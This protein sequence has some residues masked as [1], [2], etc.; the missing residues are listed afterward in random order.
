MYEFRDPTGQ[1]KMSSPFTSKV[2]KP[3]KN[4][5][6]ARQGDRF[7][8]SCASLNRRV[9]GLLFNRITQLFLDS[10]CAG[11]AFFL[12]FQLRFDGS[13]SPK[14]R[15]IMLVWLAAVIVLR[16]F[17]IWVLGAY[18]S[19]WRYFNL[20]DMFS[21]SLAAALPST[22]L[23]FARIVLA[24]TFWFMAI[25]ISIVLIDLGLFLILVG[26]LRALRRAGFESWRVS[27]SHRHRAVLLGTGDTLASGVRQ[28]SL[29]NDI[30][31]V[32]LLSPDPH[33]HGRRIAGFPVVEL[34]DDA[35]P[36]VL[37]NYCV[38][39]VFIAEA[40]LDC[41]DEIVQDTTQ[42]G[43]EVR[44]LPS[45]ANIMR[46][47]VRIS[48]KLNPEHVLD[49]RGASLETPHPDVIRGFEGKNVLITGAG[50]SIGSE[51]S[52]QVSR[53]GVNKA[54]LLDRDENSIFELQ[55]QLTELG[56]ASQIL[57]LVGD[58]RD[59]HQL[60]QIFERH[61][62]EVVLHAAAFKHVGI[63]EQNPCEAVLNNV[64]GTR[65]LA[66]L[67]IEFEAKRFL[68]ISTDK[69]VRPT[70]V[71]GATK[72]VAELLVRGLAGSSGHN[73][74]I[75][76]VRFGNVVGSR[77]S[78]VPIFLRQIAAGGP[79]T[80]THEEMTRYFMTI[81]EAVQ[82]VM[83]ASTLAS[84][85]TIYTLDLGDPLRI[86]HLAHKLIEMS[87]LRPEKDIKI[88][89]VGVRPGEKLHE[90]LWYEDCHV[91]P[92]AFARVLALE[93]QERPSIEL[94]L[95]E[96]EQAAFARQENSVLQLL[97]E[98]PIDFRVEHP[99]AMIA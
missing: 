79:V 12:A 80:I 49:G 84:N 94:E 74:Q 76:C 18:A 48:A 66:E 81:P 1:T 14:Y 34:R 87:G 63:M 4:D 44:L 7:L 13:V 35:L 71:M 98:M 82:L 37:V 86:T 27:G 46:G 92:T 33:L 19:I 65:Y 78:V 58:I 62:P 38:D 45:A 67:A 50:G 31:L 36:D 57:P 72:R 75:A 17:C 16:P 42:F 8:R 23:L 53:L 89:F 40:K 29:Q 90:Q 91:T 47:D 10:G 56:F 70:S 41:I 43:A 68:M 52:R 26:T 24:K 59:R 77:G 51:I 5:F 39:I 73:T 30:E 11:L 55:N 32:G 64:M 96:L 22:F 6:I 97:R 69:A 95:T 15:S 2:A 60:Q 93:G 20:R 88:Q 54:I 9:P 99:S 61:R 21:L 3:A 28:V 25:P 83:Q 85:G